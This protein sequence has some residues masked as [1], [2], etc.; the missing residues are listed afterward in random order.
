MYIRTD[1]E[2]IGETALIH[3]FKY[4][5]VVTFIQVPFMHNIQNFSTNLI[6][7]V[8]VVIELDTCWR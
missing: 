4:H 8:S 6:I 1:E 2:I 7:E 3:L 5:F